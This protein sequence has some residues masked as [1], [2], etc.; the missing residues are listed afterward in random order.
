[1]CSAMHGHNTT[2]LA[3]A[4]AD[5]AVS[6]RHNLDELFVCMCISPL[7]NFLSVGFFYSFCA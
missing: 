7:G 1:M 2:S 4:A 6:R 5:A 3:R